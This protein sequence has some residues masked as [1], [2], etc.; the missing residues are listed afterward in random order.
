MEALKGVSWKTPLDGIPS[1]GSPLMST[2]LIPWGVA[3]EWVTCR[4]SSMRCLSRGFVRGVP[5]FGV[6]WMGLLLGSSRC[7]TSDGPLVGSGGF[8]KGSSGGSP[9]LGVPWSGLSGG[10][11]IGGVP[12][13]SVPWRESPGGDHLGGSLEVSGGWSPELGPLEGVH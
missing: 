5:L 9:L 12:L 8:L 3:L 10:S 4:I 2:I 1:R 6:P 7:S 11:P 13:K